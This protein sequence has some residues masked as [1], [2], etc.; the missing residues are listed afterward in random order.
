MLKKHILLLFVE[1]DLALKW[2]NTGKELH[3]KHTER[4]NILHLPCNWQY[5]SKIYSN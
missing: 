3:S 5:T 2:N 1:L 4:L